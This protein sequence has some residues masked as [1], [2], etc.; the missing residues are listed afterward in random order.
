MGISLVYRPNCAWNTKIFVSIKF[1]TV[2][3]NFSVADSDSIFEPCGQ[4]VVLIFLL[5]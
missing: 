2:L 5:L 3:W 4:H 1:G